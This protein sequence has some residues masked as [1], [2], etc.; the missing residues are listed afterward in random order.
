MGVLFSSKSYTPR[1]DLMK[2]YTVS[3]KKALGRR[4]FLLGKTWRN[5]T[6]LSKLNHEVLRGL[7]MRVVGKPNTKD[8]FANRERTRCWPHLELSEKLKRSWRY[9]RSPTLSLFSTNKSTKFVKTT[10]NIHRV[11]HTTQMRART[12]NYSE[13]ILIPWTTHLKNKQGKD[14]Q[15]K[16]TWTKIKNL[17]S[18]GSIISYYRGWKYKGRLHQASSSGEETSI[19]RLST[20]LLAKSSTSGST[21]S[22]TSRYSWLS[23]SSATL[24]KG[25]SG[26]RTRTWARTFL[27]HSRYTRTTK[28]ARGLLYFRN[29]H[30]HDYGDFRPRNKM[31]D[32]SK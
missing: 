32:E 20:I 5:K 18:K 22:T 17:H 25:N 19:L 26:A 3:L 16:K 1:E 30:I 12:N 29:Y 7:P 23:A 14:I 4:L 28:Y 24:D 15:A 9:L 27:V 31:L 10:I 13:K 8:V 2:R 21:F 6:R 11:V